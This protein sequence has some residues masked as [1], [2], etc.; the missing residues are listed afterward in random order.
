MWSRLGIAGCSPAGYRASIR[1]AGL[2]ACNLLESQLG[3]CP[4][5]IQANTLGP[6]FFLRF[7]SGPVGNMNSLY[8]CNKFNSLSHFLLPWKTLRLALFFI[9]ASVLSGCSDPDVLSPEQTVALEQRV[10]ERWQTIMD[11]DF[12]K[13]WEYSTPNYRSVFSKRMFVKTFSYQIEWELTGVEV[14]HY[15]ARAAVASV[16]ARVM[17]TPTKPI[18]MASKALGTRPITV[19]EKWMLID[20]EWWHSA[21]N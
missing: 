7:F 15:D 11:R 5:L 1:N 4:P 20:G 10:R 3:Q 14:L 2:L 19:R 13:T 6:S 12:E 16:G 17:T 18:S 8:N 9:V 21:N